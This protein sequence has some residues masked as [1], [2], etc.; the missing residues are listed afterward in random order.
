MDISKDL[1]GGRTRNFKKLT[2]NDEIKAMINELEAEMDISTQNLDFER[3]A[4]LRD[5]VYELEK[6]LK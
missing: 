3:A 2:K 6:K 4:V 5:E 1:S